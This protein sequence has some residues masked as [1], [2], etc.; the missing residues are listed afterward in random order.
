VED[1]LR[2]FPADE[3][4]LVAA[5]GKDGGLEQ[6]LCEFGLPVRR[7]GGSLPLRQR[8][9]LRERARRIIAGRSKATPFAFF[10]GVNLLLFLL[11]VLISL[12]IA[13]LLWL[14]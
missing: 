6:S 8:D 14:R 13:L 1:A 7:L 4:L 3:I 12:A 9:R 10:A 5:A 11:A 2:A